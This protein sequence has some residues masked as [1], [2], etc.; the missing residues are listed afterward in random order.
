MARHPLSLVRL[1]PPAGWHDA[2][3][4][5]FVAPE[6]NGFRA[7]VL[8]THEMV[9]DTDVNVFADRQSAELAGA[10]AQYRK[11]SREKIKVGAIDAVS[12]A[13]TFAS[14]NGSVV[15]QQVVYALLGEIAYTLVMTSDEAAAES[16]ARAFAQVLAEFQ[17]G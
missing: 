10:L 7:N 11:L 1:T 13:Y 12:V 14:P 9:T 6:V 16:S 15:R 8:V 17:I 5:S 2:S 3:V 4:L